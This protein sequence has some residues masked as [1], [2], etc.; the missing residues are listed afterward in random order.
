M[1]KIG[2]K[3]LWSIRVINL[4]L[5]LHHFFMPEFSVCL[6]FFDY[7]I[8]TLNNVFNFISVCW[9]TD[10]KLNK[11]YSFNSISYYYSRS[12]FGKKI[13]KNKQS[14]WGEFFFIL[15]FHNYR[16]FLDNSLICIGYWVELQHPK[17]QLVLLVF[18][19]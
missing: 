17:K 16:H 1:N 14:I 7:I 4:N 6:I 11:C 13:G 12:S 9:Y 2:S 15:L 10:I 18:L 3:F 19:K 5:L 8:W